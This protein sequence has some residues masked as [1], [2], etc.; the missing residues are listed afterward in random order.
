MKLMVTEDQ[1]DFI[2]LFGTSACTSSGM[3]YYVPY[4]YKE[5]DNA[6]VFEAYSPDR[7]PS[8]LREAI[9]EQRLLNK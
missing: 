8:D 7:I 5:T 3:Y 1:S 4:W 2:K 9:L 6:C